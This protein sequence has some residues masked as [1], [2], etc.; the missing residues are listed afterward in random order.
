MENN[1]KCP[2]CF[3]TGTFPTVD[4]RGNPIEE[5]CACEKGDRL[6]AEEWARKDAQMDQMFSDHMFGMEYGD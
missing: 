6:A 3:D 1:T 5:Y 2:L 4:A